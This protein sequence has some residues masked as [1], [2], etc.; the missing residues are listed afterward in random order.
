MIMDVARRGKHMG[1]VK[2][3]LVSRYYRL[4]F[5]MHKGCIHDLNIMELG[6]NSKITFFSRFSIWCELMIS[7]EL[8][9]IP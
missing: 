9:V 4:E 3:I 2:N 7:G 6:N 8:V 1:G 5:R